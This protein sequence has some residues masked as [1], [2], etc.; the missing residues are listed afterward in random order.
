M[1]RLHAKPNSNY[2]QFPEPDIRRILMGVLKFE[3]TWR[4]DQKWL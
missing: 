3:K 2:R 4:P 1:E